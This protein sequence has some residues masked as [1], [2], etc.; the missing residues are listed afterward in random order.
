MNFLF[1]KKT[2]FWNHFRTLR[3]KISE[4]YPEFLAVFQ[5]CIIRVDRI[6]FEE[7]WLCA[8]YNTLP[9]LSDNEQKIFAFLSRNI[10]SGS[11]NCIL[12]HHMKIVWGSF[13]R[14]FFV[15]LR[16]LNEEVS[17]Y[18]RTFMR[19]FR[20]WIWNWKEFNFFPSILINAKKTFGL[21][22][23]N[24]GSGCQNCILRHHFEISKDYCFRIFF[25]LRTLNEEHS[26]YCPNFVRGCHNRILHVPRKF[27]W[28][29]FLRNCN[30]KSVF[31]FE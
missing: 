1:P 30:F 2:R 5:N 8:K 3:D 17:V 6:F 7:K 22:S 23:I 28:N 16:S 25:L 13:V 15:L 27:F 12:C 24:I 4:F 29:C 21:L 11:Q 19:G 9:A 31:D 18:C 20:N 14:N 26:V 10:W